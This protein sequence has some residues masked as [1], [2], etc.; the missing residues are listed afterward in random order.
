MAGLY[1]QTEL[2]NQPQGGA[3]RSLA[4]DRPPDSITAASGIAETI[5]AFFSPRGGEFT[6]SA[7]YAMAAESLT[8]LTESDEGFDAF[9]AIRGTKWEAAP[10]EFIG[11]RNKAQFERRVRDLEDE[12]LNRSIIERAGFFTQL[13]AGLATGVVDPVNWVGFGGPI[14]KGLKAGTRATAGRE[15]LVSGLKGGVVSAGVQETVLQEANAHRTWQ[16]SVAAVAISGG[17]TALLGGAIGR[18]IGKRS[19]TE[20]LLRGKLA[21]ATDARLRAGPEVLA[22]IEGNTVPLGVGPMPVDVTARVADLERRAVDFEA[23]A[24]EPAAAPL[25]AGVMTIGEDGAARRAPA[26]YAREAERLRSEAANLRKPYGEVTETV[27]PPNVSRE[28][29]VPQPA[30][31]VPR[32]TRWSGDDEGGVSMA[33]GKSLSSA[34][35]PGAG[36]VR[37]QGGKKVEFLQAPSR[38]LGRW[39]SLFDSPVGRALTSPIMA[40]RRTTERL[41]NTLRLTKNLDSYVDVVDAGGNVVG[42]E[43][44]SGEAT[45]MSVEAAVNHRRGLEAR[46]VTR[47]RNLYAEYRRE[48]AGKTGPQIAERARI[49]L[50]DATKVL[51][52]GTMSEMEFRA[53]AYDVVRDGTPSGIKEVDELAAEVTASIDKLKQDALA[54]ELL[55]PGV[56]PVT[57]RNY[58]MR[59]YDREMVK[60]RKPLAVK[61]LSLW[62]K[63]NADALQMRADEAWKVVADLEQQKVDL[64]AE[65]TPDEQRIYLAEGR[66]RDAENRYETVKTERDK[67]VDAYNEASSRVLFL[68]ASPEAPRTRDVIA[69]ATNAARLIEQDLVAADVELD[70]ARMAR[71]AQR[72]QLKIYEN[73][74]EKWP[75]ALERAK[76]ERRTA[77]IDLLRQQTYTARNALRKLEG[78][79]AARKGSVENYREWLNLREQNKPAG[80]RPTSLT[81]HITSRGKDGKQIAGVRIWVEDAD[82]NRVTTSEGSDYLEIVKD[83]LK[84]NKAGDVDVRERLSRLISDDPD[85]PTVGEAAERYRSFVKTADETFNGVDD[86]SINEFLE[87]VSQDLSSLRGPKGVVNFGEYAHGGVRRSHVEQGRVYDTEELDAVEGWREWDEIRDR[88]RELEA[89]QD[90][91]SGREV[92]RLLNAWRERAAHRYGESEKALQ[93]VIEERNALRDALDAKVSRAKDLEKNRQRLDKRIET[94]TA[95]AKEQAGIAEKSEAEI[96]G[97][98]NRL[99]DD[100]IGVPGEAS[101]WNADQFA[102]KRG[103]LADRTLLI[104]DTYDA[105]PISIG[106]ETVSGRF[107]QFLVK[108]TDRIMAAMLRNMAPDIELTRAFGGI[109][110]S[111]QIDEI[112]DDAQ[113]MIA[114]EVRKKEVG[115]IRAGSDDKVRARVIRAHEKRVAEISREQKE[116]IK[117]LEV[118]V[119]RLRGTFNTGVDPDSMW[120]GAA[121]NLKAIN[122]MR[123]MGSAVPASLADPMMI[124]NAHGFRSLIKGVMAT[125]DWQAF[126]AEM[127]SVREK[128][129]QALDMALAVRS[130]AIADMNSTFVPKGRA[131][132]TLH[133][134]N[135]RFGFVNLLGPWTDFWKTVDVLV[136]QDRVLRNS[137]KYVRG[138]GLDDID[139]AFMRDHFIDEGGMVLISQMQ[140]QVKT[141]GG[142]RIAETNS[143]ASDEARRLF[144]AAMNKNADF[145][146]ITPGLDKPIWMST[147]AGSVV[148]QFKSYS[149]VS[150]NRILAANLQKEASTAALGLS[151]LATGGALSYL[152]SAALKGDDPTDE[153]IEKWAGE[154]IDRSGMLGYLGEVNALAD[155]FGF[156]I[157]RI[158]G[159]K[160][161]SRYASRSWADQVFGPSFGLMMNMGGV[162]QALGSE[163]IDLTGTDLGNVRS[164][165]PG[166]NVPIVGRWLMDSVERGAAATLGVE[167]RPSI[168]LDRE[169]E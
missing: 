22:E 109:N 138:E 37:L 101:A 100:I 61:V 119:A 48:L 80:G 144:S 65:M 62:L 82:G 36:E 28:T 95:R 55:P 158:L 120:M 59:I 133:W 124:A 14:A 47:G 42:R 132:R 90:F 103:P 114:L 58:I 162:A 126:K 83:Y 145:N 166:Q 128:Y 68:S 102:T 134:M 50:A 73:T 137:E 154:A 34:A 165:V 63:D 64:L 44:I 2:M 113:A 38:F 164:L 72:G 142:L 71:D 88:K 3:M 123:L 11:I 5:G 17:F 86:Y 8:R 93:A 148:G 125:M 153:P 57:A 54:V 39:A 122:N 129:G 49:A 77:R 87:A 112:R 149:F 76:I 16:E 13:V 20:A 151:L 157:N 141:V 140:P 1:S 43:R 30:N 33:G 155:K 152:V 167:P 24:A 163:D 67:L 161:G 111:K 19:E 84:T 156:G 7:M 106:G 74:T 130:N 92:T 159:T 52:A 116:M 98:A 147:T 104:P 108:D 160:P 9:N 27:I 15:Y 121:E 168:R 41:A 32:I 96:E 169:A 131:T 135:Q 127:R 150:M 117:L 139:L 23:R 25:P 51:P 115:L 46:V 69:D 89:D 105:G 70:A 66:V 12:D 53:A 143:W 40:A 45:A 110:M 26:D 75:A 78:E 79:F 18:K 85:A 107:D 94:E 99:W 6:P 21:A 146:V 97:I 10:G 118:Q 60:A 35:T 4:E 136:A 31:D 56:D 91:R 81:E 29:R